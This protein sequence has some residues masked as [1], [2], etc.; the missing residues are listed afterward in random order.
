[1]TRPLG[2]DVDDNAIRFSN[3]FHVL[4]ELVHFTTAGC[5]LSRAGSASTRSATTST[6]TL[7][8][9][10]RSSVACTSYAT[11][12][13]GARRVDEL[14]ELLD[15]MASATSAQE[16]L[17]VAYTE[18]KPALVRAMRIHLDDLDPVADEPSL[19]LFTQIVERQERHTDGHG[20]FDA[21]IG[22]SPSGSGPSRASSASS[23]RSRS[24]S[25][26]SSWRSPRP[27]TPTFARPVRERRGKPPCRSSARSSSTSF[28]G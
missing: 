16:Y 7:A 1:M 2:Y 5:R 19:R 4:R 12:R 9:G 25:G 27:A 15:R 10:P 11:Q 23:L 18:A 21:D 20:S 8:R 22:S 3:Y 28:T 24:R 26:T 14:N 17:T 6:T 13:T